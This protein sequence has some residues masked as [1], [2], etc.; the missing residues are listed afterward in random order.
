MGKIGLGDKLAILPHPKAPL[1]SGKRT[2]TRL[3]IAHVISEMESPNAQIRGEI[4]NLMRQL[5]Y[6]SL[7]FWLRYIASYNGPYDLLNED[8][9][10]DMC[11]FRQSEYCMADGARA[12]AFIPRDMFKSTIFTHGA[13]G[14]EGLRN[15][16][17][18]IGIANAIAERAGEF[19][20]VIKSTFEKNELVAELFPEYVPKPGQERWN[21]NEITFPNR[22][23]HYKEPSVDPF[24]ATGSGEGDHYD[25]FVVD[26]P[27][28]MEDIGSEYRSNVSMS[29]RVKWFNTAK[30]A[31]PMSLKSR[32]VLVMTR[33]A[34]DDPGQLVMDSARK[35]VG[36]KDPEFVEREDGEWTVYYRMVI[37][38]GKP[39]FP[40]VMD[41]KTIEIMMKEDPWT[42]LTQYYNHPQKAGLVEFNEFT[43]LSGKM[44]YKNDEMYVMHEG[45]NFGVE[46]RIW[47]IS[48]CHVVMSLDPAFSDKGISAKTSRTSLAVWCMDPEGYQY[49][50]WARV[51]YFD[52][53]KTID[54][55]VD[56]VERFEG[57]IDGIYFETNGAQKQLPRIFRK[58]ANERGVFLP[59][60][61]KP[62]SGDKVARIRQTVGIALAKGKVV[63]CEGAATEFLEEMKL[64]PM[65]EFK[66]DVLDESEKALRSLVLPQSP[67]DRILEEYE[68]EDQIWATDNVTGY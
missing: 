43:P 36:Y 39:I 63:L 30:R 10:L 49:R 15:P 67:E 66:R 9:H 55:M 59:L 60:Y 38:D 61:G 42:V 17:I 20:R 33:Y 6:V 37:E 29:N 54:Y 8:L 50:L 53:Y 12:A 18:R 52:I 19:M 41:E 27:A 47:P 3:M 48:D 16:D 28:G 22:T 13:G 31:L 7:F 56:G 2:D 14:W 68:E 62:E 11:N 57:K 25:L 64:F 5:S 34:V 1:F 35:F 24:G 32:I 58:E 26:D 23:K 45:N 44:F 40:E 65:A 21:Q 4:V 46:E 51:G